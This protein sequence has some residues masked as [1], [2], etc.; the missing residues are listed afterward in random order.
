MRRYKASVAFDS[1]CRDLISSATL[2]F[3]RAP[4]VDMTCSDLQWTV[5][6]K[7]RGVPLGGDAGGSQRH[8]KGHQDV[9]LAG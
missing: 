4:A 6:A 5:A 2:C 1:T 8:L 3:E 9:G 7:H